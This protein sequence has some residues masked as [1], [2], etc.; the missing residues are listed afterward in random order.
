MDKR[1]QVF[2]SSTYTDLK[3]ERRAIIQT[4]IEM[5]CIPA[6]MEL[7]PAADE[8]QFQFI[9][10]IVD[11]CDYYI[12]IIGGRYGSTTP[13]GL[14]YTEKEYDYAR[15]MG[16]KILSF[17]HEKPG[18]IEFDKSDV[19]PGLRTRLEA[20]RGK[21]KTGSIVKFWSDPKELPGLV[22]VSLARTIKAHPAIGWVR[23]NQI[24]NTQA[25]SEL[26]E[27]RKRNQELESQLSDLTPAIDNLAGLDDYVEL[28]GDYQSGNYRS[29]SS[30]SVTWGEIVA[31]IAP[32]IMG[33][34][35]DALMHTNFSNRMREL[36]RSKHPKLDGSW[37]IKDQDFQT[38]KIQMM[39]LNLVSV[40]MEQTTEGGMALF[41]SLTPRGEAVLLQL[42][43][44]KKDLKKNQT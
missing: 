10:S 31:T 26:N 1:Y 5:D 39:A 22:A 25:L 32:D 33:Q 30:M 35:N 4:L 13:D 12:L 16:L 9:K 27:L 44:L 3:D 42:R 14:S 19:D 34:P 7:F 20:F 43:T 40:R 11:D 41:W 24:A 28:S 29:V 23:A 37:R 18:S 17:I 15:E 6:G 38:V 21:A 36:F 8:E 2:V